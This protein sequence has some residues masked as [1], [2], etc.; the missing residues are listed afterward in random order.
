MT[1]IMLVSEEMLFLEWLKCQVMQR[2]LDAEEAVLT[3]WSWQKF[4]FY[5]PGA[6]ILSLE[7]EHPQK[8]NKDK[9]I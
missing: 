7:T 6:T 3:T 9:I 8:K 4:S 1:T 5:F 2:W